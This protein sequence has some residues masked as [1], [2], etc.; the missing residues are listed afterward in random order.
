MDLTE[1]KLITIR[2]AFSKMK[3]NKQIFSRQLEAI[4][5]KSNGDLKQNNITEIKYTKVR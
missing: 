3:D 1:K 5:L 4:F 2:D